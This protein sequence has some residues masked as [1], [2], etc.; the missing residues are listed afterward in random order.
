MASLERF[1]AGRVA[2]VAAILLS[3]EPASAHLRA[4]RGAAARRGILHGRSGHLAVDPVAAGRA[5]A[6]VDPI[7][8][9]FR[10]WDRGR[11]LGHVHLQIVHLGQSEKG[12]S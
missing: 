3:P 7:L 6:P 8:P 9:V 11:R 1:R 12:V 10:R 4:P 2:P 5:V